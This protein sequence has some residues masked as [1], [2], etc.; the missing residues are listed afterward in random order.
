VRA[1]IDSDILIWHLRGKHKARDFIRR[2]QK[3]DEFELW[4]G[5]MQRAEIIFFMRPG[6]E[7]ASELFLSLFQTAPVDQAIIDTA[8]GLYRKWHPSHGIDIHDAILASTAI[9]NSDS[10]LNE[11]LRQ[12]GISRSEFDSR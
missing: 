7:E 12:V 5:E 4:T 10:L 9:D 1:Y 3:A 2:V 8:G 11:I 6:E